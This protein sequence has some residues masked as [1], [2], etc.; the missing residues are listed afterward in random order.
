MSAFQ[1]RHN[2]RC[3]F[4]GT[5]GSGKTTLAKALLWGKRS[6]YVLDPK[7]TFGVPESWPMGSITY[8][9][10]PELRRHE[11]DET[12]IYRPSPEEMKSYCD[13]FFFHIFDV[14]NCIVFVDEIMSVCPSGRIGQG[15]AHCIQLGRERGIGTWS[16]TQ[17][18]A[19][20]PLVTMTESEHY[21]VF[22][23]K[24]PDDRKRMGAYADPLLER[25]VPDKNGF[26]DY[27]ENTQIVKYYKKANVGV[28]AS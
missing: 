14:S 19:M 6:V 9:S 21:F 23:L 28:L 10:L 1:I 11:T 16:A 27:N 12:A 5:T 22:R 24:N 8:T 18:P 26:F 25:K 2:E 17:R 3:F 7:R 15:Y 20:V 4:V 13:D